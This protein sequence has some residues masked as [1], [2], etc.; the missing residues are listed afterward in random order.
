MKELEIESILRRAR[1]VFFLEAGDI[2][3]DFSNNIFNILHR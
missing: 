1:L 2:M 3:Q